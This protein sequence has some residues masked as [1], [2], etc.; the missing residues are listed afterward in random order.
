MRGETRCTLAFWFIFSSQD[1]AIFFIPVKT[2]A[3][4][5]AAVQ[6]TEFA[7]SS[8]VHLQ[9]SIKQRVKSCNPGIQAVKTV[10]YKDS[11]S[12]EKNHC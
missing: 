4:G 2:I 11:A 6:L 9:H 7:R 5:G 3:D 8:R 10:G 12:K 1:S